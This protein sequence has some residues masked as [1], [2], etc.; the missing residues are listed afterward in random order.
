MFDVDKITALLK[1]A[2]NILPNVGVEL[3]SHEVGILISTTHRHQLDYWS[4][5]EA[6]RRLPW[7]TAWSSPPRDPI[8]VTYEVIR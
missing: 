3:T 5:I 1:D 2:K 7:Y 8:D 4:R 6:V